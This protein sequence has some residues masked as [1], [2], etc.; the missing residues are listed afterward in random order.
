MAYSSSHPTSAVLAST[1]TSSSI[2]QQSNHN[3]ISHQQSLALSSRIVSKKAEL[4]NLMRLRDLSGV[5]AM[6][7]QV[8]ETKIGTLKDGTEAVACVLANWDNVIRAISMASTKAAVS[9]STKD[10]TSNVETDHN[11]MVERRL[12]ATLVRIPVEERER[13]QD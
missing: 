8:L 2:R 10:Q 9:I 7:M 12:P 1:S 5:M 6:Q 11:L 13:P 4:E 3:A